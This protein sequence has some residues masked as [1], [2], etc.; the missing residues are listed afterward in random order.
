M[1]DIEVSTNEIKYCINGETGV[2]EE[3]VINSY[4]EW[5]GK[6]DPSRLIWY[7][8]LMASLCEAEELW[9]W[10]ISQMIRFWSCK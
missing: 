1:K 9:W 8:E 6:F 5:E 3:V 4:L 10:H 2:F 7:F